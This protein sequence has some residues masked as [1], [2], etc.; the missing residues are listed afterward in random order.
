MVSEL[1]GT[2]S[3]LNEFEF[4]H[5]ARNISSINHM[6]QFFMADCDF[7]LTFAVAMQKKQAMIHEL[8]NTFSIIV[9][10]S[11]LVVFGLLFL[12]VVIPERPLLR[13][14]RKARWM[15]TCAYLFF[16][17]VNGVEYAFRDAAGDNIPLTLTVTLAIAFSQSFLFTW[18]LITLLNVRWMERRRSCREL[19]LVLT[20]IAAIFTV[21]FL[22]PPTCFLPAFYGLIL[23]YAVQLVRY[24]RMFVANYRRFGRQIDNYFSD[25]ETVRLRWVAFTFY[26]ALALGVLVLLPALFLAD[27]P[28]LLL[29][30]AAVWFFYIFFGIR[31]LNYAF[32]FHF[33]ETAVDDGPMP[34]A[35]EPV[36]VGQDTATTAAYAAIEKKLDNWVADKQ[37]TRQGITVDMLAAELFTNRNYLSSY[38]NR[39]RKQTFREWIN[40]LRI[41]EAKKLLLQHPKLSV[42]D[43]AL[44]T[45]FAGNSNFGRRF[46]KQTG[47]TPKKWRENHE[48]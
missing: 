27:L 48:Q 44:R 21:Y 47:L 4:V 26:G 13:S 24:T 31:F 41:E 39:R 16:A 8:Y 17:L 36:D 1:I 38:I 23:L 9:T 25:T 15:M 43:I 2:V 18:T 29:T 45:G 37:F 14:Y 28:A 19:T 7:S 12:F 20:F 6:R 30:T 22:C 11:V 33:I 3:E 5:A 46:L 42:Q 10:A 40:E 34:T 32:R 35:G